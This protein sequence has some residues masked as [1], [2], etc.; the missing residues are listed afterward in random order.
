MDRD[1]LSSV[2]I[3]AGRV[4]VVASSDH[5]QPGCV[6]FGSPGFSMGRICFRDVFTAKAAAALRMPA[7]QV[8]SCCDCFGLAVAETEERRIH[9][10]VLDSF[11]HQEPVETSANHARIDVTLWHGHPPNGSSAR[12]RT[13]RCFRH[14]GGPLSLPCLS[15]QSK[16]HRGRRSPLGASHGQGRPNTLQESAGRPAP[17]LSR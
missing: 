12:A 1:S 8:S 9:A 7:S 3:E 5:V 16:E 10:P 14:P 15:S 11:E 4:G 13:A 17:L 2:I 6:F